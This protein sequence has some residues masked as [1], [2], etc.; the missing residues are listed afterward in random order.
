M[1]ITTKDAPQ[2]AFKPVVV[3]ITCDTQ[4]ELDAIATVLCSKLIDDAC[5][6]IWPSLAAERYALGN[7][8]DMA[9]IP[10]TTNLKSAIEDILK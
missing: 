1:R 10:Q 9:G 2:P 6:A 8:S 4:D 3:E 5:K 7:I